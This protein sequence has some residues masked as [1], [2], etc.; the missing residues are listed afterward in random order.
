M[1][2]AILAAAIATL[3]AAPAA[4]ANVTIYGQVHVSIDSFNDDGS[5]DIW[6]VKSRASRIGF[7]G[8]EDLGNGLSLIWKA[9]TGYDF[10]D[11]GAWD[12]TGR[13]AYIGLT[14][15][16]GTF[17]Y[18]RHDTPYKMA[19]YSTGIDVMGDTAMDMNALAP[20]NEVRAS[21]AIAYVSPNFN[22]LTFAAAIVPGEGA[23]G[24]V[25]DT[26]DG[27]ADIWSVGVM[28]S[29]NG[30]K[31]AAAYEDLAV[32]ADGWTGT[33]AEGNTKWLVGAGYT[34]N[35]LYVGVS[36]QN[37]EYGDD[38][39]VDRTLNTWG[40]AGTYTFGNNML[41]VNYAKS[42]QGDDDA[43][44]WGIGLSHKLS[45]RTSAYVVYAD[46]E[47]DGMTIVTLGGAPKNSTSDIT[48]SSYGDDGSMFSIGMIHKF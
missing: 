6:Q 19:F 16:W 4:N 8:T 11:G 41:A 18:G 2:K 13:N 26:M 15:D 9:E 25:N 1:K 29:N 23:D 42:D 10:A 28:Y 14:G 33:G 48:D 46:A 12:S 17:L 32:E 7:K 20:F 36:Y 24:P 47:N 37:W 5:D 45:K 43:T 34:M 39:D 3:V 30:L 21:N 35:N 22:G 31:L 38:R 27:L 40:V 44:G